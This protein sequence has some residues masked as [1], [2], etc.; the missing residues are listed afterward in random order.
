MK[1]QAYAALILAALFTISRAQHFDF[2]TYNVQMFMNTTSRI[3]TYETTQNTSFVC[4]VDDMVN[5]TEDYVFFNRSYWSSNWTT[6]TLEGT[7]SKED[8]STMFV[9]GIGI[10]P[11]HSETLEFASGNY[12]CGVFYVKL[13]GGNLAWR[14]LRFKDVNETGK[15]HE[16]CM[17][18]FNGT[19]Q[20]GYVIYNDTCKNLQ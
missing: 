18:Y 1:K 3:W 20:T 19:R 6:V 8:L 5:I 2:R 9:G 10:G 15:P 17:Q 11:D 14:E 4:K 7:F 16:Q 13:S 12:T